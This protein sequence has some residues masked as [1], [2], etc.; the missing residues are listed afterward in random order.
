MS[1]IWSFFCRGSTLQLTFSEIKHMYHLYIV[2]K[3]CSSGDRLLFN[4]VWEYYHHTNIISQYE[5]CFGI[6][7]NLSYLTFLSI[8]FHTRVEVL[9]VRYPYTLTATQ[10]NVI[11][12]KLVQHIY[13]GNYCFGHLC[14]KRFRMVFFKIIFSKI[15][16]QIP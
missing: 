6:E 14:L 15:F 5:I 2:N 10:S 4:Y 3:I 12:K 8:C 1:C 11:P 13:I 7:E 9:S 16:C